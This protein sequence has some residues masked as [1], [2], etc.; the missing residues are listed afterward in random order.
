[1]I[2]SRTLR[3]KLRSDGATRSCPLQL[4]TIG[5]RRRVTSRNGTWSKRMSRKG[6]YS[7]GS[8]T[9]S[10]RDPSWFKKGSTRAPP[11][12]SAP[13]PPLSLA[14]KAAFEALKQSKEVGVRLIPKGE[15]KK[16]KSRFGKAKSL[17]DRPPT[18]IVRKCSDPTTYICGCH[19]TSDFPGTYM[20]CS[21]VE[22]QGPRGHYS[23]LLGDF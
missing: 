1:V 21:N 18:T 9:I 22:L 4:P 19:C 3:S 17:G 20:P 13:K 14:E 7:G 8:T 15:K 16:R 2:W 5:H 12:E 11:N 10:P 23:R 6:H